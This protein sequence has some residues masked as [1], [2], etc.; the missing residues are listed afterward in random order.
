M[1]AEH[2]PTISTVNIY[3]YWSWNTL[4]KDCSEQGSQIQ[5]QILLS[6]NDRNQP[7]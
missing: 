1:V 7:Q 3:Q 4:G 5:G 2:D 6:L